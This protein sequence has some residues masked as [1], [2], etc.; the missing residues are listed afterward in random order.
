MRSLFTNFMKTS[1]GKTVASFFTVLVFVLS[2]L[3]AQTQPDVSFGLLAR[4][5]AGLPTATLRPPRTTMTATAVIPTLTASPTLSPTAT[6]TSGASPTPS[7]V[8][9]IKKWHAPSAEPGFGHHHGVN[10]RDYV[11]IFGPQLETFLDTYGEISYPWSTPDE[12]SFFGYGHHTSYVWLY[13]HARNGGCEL[14]NNGGQLPTDTANCITDVL[15]ELHSD[16][17][18]KHLRK[19][20]H[21]HYVFMRV[22]DQALT[23]CGIVSTGG[24]GDYGILETP[25]KQTWCPLPGIDPLTP[26]DGWDLNQPP[27]RTSMTAYRPANLAPLFSPENFFWDQLDPRTLPMVVQFWSGLRPNFINSIPY[28]LKNDQLYPANMPNFTVGLAWSS[29]DAWGIVNPLSC[30]DP[31][32]DT[33]VSAD[34][35][36]ALNNSAFQ[37]FSVMLYQLPEP[38]PLVGYKTLW[39]NRWGLPVQGCV[40]ASVDCVPLTIGVG[41]PGPGLAMLNRPVQQGDP[42]AAPILEF[43][44]GGGV[45]LPAPVEP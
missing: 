17:T 33:F 21:S 38:A 40:N 34:G 24:W 26:A 32:L 36:S 42:T 15:I 3:T 45:I 8:H 35:S 39:T 2:Y 20:F 9:D 19:R 12:N 28:D 43:D 18:Q 30:A 14:F 10:P 6:P 23:T 4:P 11:S 27:Y 7:S 16:G 5:T 37:V 44:P 41:A 13:Q 1:R 25:Y 29:L 22:C 31:E